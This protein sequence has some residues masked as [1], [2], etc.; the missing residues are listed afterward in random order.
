MKSRL[1]LLMTAAAMATLPMQGVVAQDTGASPDMSRRV[2][3]IERELRAVQRRVFPGAQDGLF[4]PEVQPADTNVVPGVAGATPV[5]EL[6]T[7]VDAIE[8]QLARLT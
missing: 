8:A 6:T 1:F 7:R 3:R 5:A 4:Q 2:D